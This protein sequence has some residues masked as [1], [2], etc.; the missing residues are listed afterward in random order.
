LYFI[1]LRRDDV[2]AY[3]HMCCRQSLGNGDVEKAFWDGN[4]QNLDAVGRENFGLRMA[5]VLR[6]RSFADA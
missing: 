2:P 6:E 5:R 4:Y 1:H 3:F